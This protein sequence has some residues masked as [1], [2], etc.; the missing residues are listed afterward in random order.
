MKRTLRFVCQ[1]V[2]RV[3]ADLYAW[4]VDDA[5]ENGRTVAQ[6]VR[7]YLT[8]ARAAGLAGHR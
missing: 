4:L 1:L 2:V 3:D 6:S 7:W 5:D 8:A